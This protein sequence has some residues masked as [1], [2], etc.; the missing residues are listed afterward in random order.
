[1]EFGAAGLGPGDGFSPRRGQAGSDLPCAQS[2]FCAQSL[3]EARIDH[4]K[5]RVP[6]LPCSLTRS[7]GIPRDA[8]CPVPESGLGKGRQKGENCG[9]SG[10][11]T[12]RV[13]ALNYS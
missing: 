11:R 7:V 13:N 4:C 12:H 2:L 10:Q 6:E 5:A 1:M 9:P 8:Q 3:G